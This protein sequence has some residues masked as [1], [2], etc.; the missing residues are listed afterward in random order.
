MFLNTHTYV[1][2]QR[3]CSQMGGCCSAQPVQPQQINMTP[4]PPPQPA[5]RSEAEV[6]HSKSPSIPPS[7]WASTQPSS[8]SYSVYDPSKNCITPGGTVMNV[9]PDGTMF[10]YN[11]SQKQLVRTDTQSSL[12]T[13]SAPAV[14]QSTPSPQPPPTSNPIET[15]YEAT[16][17]LNS[18]VPISTVPGST[19]ATTGFL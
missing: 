5:Q 3:F 8:P 4:S 12:M 1:I 6:A 9:A 19:T 11:Q 16:L 18:H 17:A 13:Q 2:L 15:V 14:L 7:H 10:H